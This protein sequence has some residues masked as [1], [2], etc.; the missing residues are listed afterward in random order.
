MKEDGLTLVV[1]APFELR[2]ALDGGRLR[3]TFFITDHY[4][5]T[6][7][8]SSSTLTRVRRAELAALLGQAVEFVGRAK[9]PARG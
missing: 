8:A 5:D 1:R 3:V 2:E 7:A 4:A 6:R 9:H